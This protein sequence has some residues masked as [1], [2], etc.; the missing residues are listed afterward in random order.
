MAANLRRFAAVIRPVCLSKENYHN[1]TAAHHALGRSD[2]QG[3]MSLI[4]PRIIQF[5][6]DVT[7]LRPK[8]AC[9]ASTASLRR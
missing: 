4:L 8:N 6:K 1:A 9:V 2:A 5:L 3:L 7:P